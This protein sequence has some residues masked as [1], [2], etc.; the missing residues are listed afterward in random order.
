MSA[1]PD[2][3]R[4]QAAVLGAAG[5]AIT[6]RA[7]DLLVSVGLA[8]ASLTTA[9]TVDGVPVFGARVDAAQPRTWEM[10]RAQHPRT[11]L[12]PF[13]SKESPEQWALRSAGAPGA[14]QR[15]SS[16]LAVPPSEV[17]DELI[18]AHRAGASRYE[19][20][21]GELTAYRLGLFDV[22]R[23]LT[24]LT[25]DP[26]SAPWRPYGEI[27]GTSA[28]PDWLCL[29]PAR[30]GY[31]LP[32]LL[33][34]PHVNDWYASK[35]HDRLTVTDHVGVLR[36]WQ[37]RFG[38]DVRYLG[39]VALGLVVATPPTDPHDVARVAVEQFA[40][41]DDLDQFVGEPHRV[42]QHQVPTHR[43]YFWWD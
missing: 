25:S 43:W 29:V 10:M 11:G 23:T 19:P 38:A 40:Y 39:V 30:A 21:D 4:K 7:R 41:C 8:P 2:N 20:P 27:A 16:A 26:P 5:R 12:W 35:E 24:L 32:A 3:T 18:A 6:A 42:A 15:L 28:D 13:F 1:V 22:D 31:E 17:V 33:G 36:S 34:A 37:Q 14:P 9:A